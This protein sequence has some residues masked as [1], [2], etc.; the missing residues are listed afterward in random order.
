MP[1]ALIERLTHW[2]GGKLTENQ[3]E[4]HICFSY[5]NSFPSTLSNCLFRIQYVTIRDCFY[6]LCICIFYV[7][8]LDFLIMSHI[9][10][11]LCPLQW[12]AQP[13]KQTSVPSACSVLLCLPKLILIPL[14]YLPGSLRAAASCSCFSYLYTF[15]LESDD[16]S[17]P[18]QITQAI[19]YPDAMSLSTPINCHTAPCWASLSIYNTCPNFLN[20]WS[21]SWIQLHVNDLCYATNVISEKY[22]R[23]WNPI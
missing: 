22:I 3:S 4:A 2:S 5:Q 21:S 12:Q 17:L 20:S 7:V 11:G 8:W 10:I 9:F 18:R 6:L 13:L 15:L 23:S 16:F 14:L 19:P 1:K